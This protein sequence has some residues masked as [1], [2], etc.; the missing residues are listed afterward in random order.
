MSAA[1]ALGSLYLWCAR[2]GRLRL[3][4]IRHEAWVR[5]GVSSMPSGCRAVGRSLPPENWRLEGRQAQQRHA[6]ACGRAGARARARGTRIGARGL[7]RPRTCARS[8]RAT[9]GVRGGAR[10]LSH[11]SMEGSRTTGPKSGAGNFGRT[12]TLM[13]RMLTRIGDVCFGDACGAGFRKSLSPG[14]PVGEPRSTGILCAAPTM[15]DA[16]ECVW[17]SDPGVLSIKGR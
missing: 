16:Y 11:R 13:A 1:P 8:A 15:N 4:G 3:T 9:C 2:S 7:S 14:C 12:S 10:V 6:V 17:G 5:L